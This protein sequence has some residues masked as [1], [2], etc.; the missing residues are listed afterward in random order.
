MLCG[1][2]RF[3]DPDRSRDKLQPAEQDRSNIQPTQFILKL[4]ILIGFWGWEED[5]NGGA[6]NDPAVH[7]E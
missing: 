3:V 1:F 2:G 5:L 7:G 6:A 4:F